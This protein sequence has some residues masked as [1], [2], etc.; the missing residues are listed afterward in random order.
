MTVCQALL[1]TV[2]CRTGPDCACI[3]RTPTQTNDSLHG[4]SQCRLPHLWQVAWPDVDCWPTAQEAWPTP[5]QLN[6]TASATF[7]PSLLTEYTHLQSPYLLH[8][9]RCC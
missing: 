1:A 8:Y 4:R 9:S 6:C 5:G 2:M 7:H 3:A